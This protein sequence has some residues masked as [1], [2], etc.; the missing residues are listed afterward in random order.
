M[1]RGHLQSGSRLGHAQAGGFSCRV[2]P[3][4]R[5]RRHAGGLHADRDR[6]VDG[7]VAAEALIEV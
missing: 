1:Q 7:F 5:R 3:D 4:L 2:V 6:P